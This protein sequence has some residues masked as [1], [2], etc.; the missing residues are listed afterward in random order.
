MEKEEQTSTYFAT[1]ERSSDAEIKS[2]H[3]KILSQKLFVSTLDTL[4]EILL[5]VNKNRQIIYLNDL[6][7]KILGPI[8]LKTIYGLKPGE[9]FHCQ[10]ATEAPAGCGTSEHCKTCGLLSAILDTQN[11]GLKSESEYRLTD[12]TGEA[13][14]F[15]VSTL[16]IEADGEIFIRISLSDISDEK[17]RQALERIFFHD[18]MNIAGGIQ[19]ISSLLKS[20]YSSD[21]VKDFAEMIVTASNSLIDEITAQKQLKMAEKGELSLQIEQLNSSKIIKDLIMIYSKHEVAEEKNIISEPLEKSIEFQSDKTILMRV[22]GN[23]LKN[24]LESTI[25]GGEVKIG[26]TS[27][28]GELEFYVRNMTYIPYETQL[29]IFQRSFSTKGEGRGLGTYSIK[30]LGE[31]YLKG[32]VRFTSEKNSG[33]TFFLRLKTDTEA[34]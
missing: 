31:K 19:G 32:K 11:S 34:N 1:A 4:Q 10:H 33:T 16:T 8:D 13:L 21:Q 7:L 14:E 29:Q 28:D 23:M 9:M 6:I 27:V 20:N 18:I 25:S 30:L 2:C 3:K 22:I 12:E 24:A 5:I 15:K 17:R 26:C